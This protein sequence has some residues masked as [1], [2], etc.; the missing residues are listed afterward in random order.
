MVI[1]RAGCK[2]G[3]SAQA[4]SAHEAKMNLNQEVRHKSEEIQDIVLNDVVKALLR[5]TKVNHEYD[6]PYIAG[7]SVDARPVFIDRHLPR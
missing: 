3:I 7:Y 4:L 6:I 2:Y 5:R 1:V